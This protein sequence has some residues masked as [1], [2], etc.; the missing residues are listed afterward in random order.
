MCG[1][2]CVYEHVC[3][4]TCVTVYT[5]V[6]S[7]FI[8]FVCMLSECASVVYYSVCVHLLI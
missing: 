2:W 8:L 5:C 7:V 6:L 1:H 3:V 4:P